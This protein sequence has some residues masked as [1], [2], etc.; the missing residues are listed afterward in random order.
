MTSDTIAQTAAGASSKMS[1]SQ[2]T[3]SASTLSKPSKAPSS[4]HSSL[5]RKDSIKPVQQQNGKVSSS[6]AKQSVQGARN[7][8]AA[9]NGKAAS[10]QS[11]HHAEKSHQK[12]NK[13]HPAPS[14][15]QKSRKHDVTSTGVRDKVTAAAAVDDRVIARQENQQTTKKQSLS[16]ETMS[17][18][19]MNRSLLL[20][21]I[22]KNV[23]GSLSVPLKQH[24][25]EKQML[26]GFFSVLD[27]MNGENSP[28]HKKNKQGNKKFR[29]KQI[30]DNFVQQL[31]KELLRAKTKLNL[32]KTSNGDDGGVASEG[33]T[34]AVRIDDQS[35]KK[36]SSAHKN[37]TSQSPHKNSSAAAHSTTTTTKD[38][39]SPPASSSAT[40][41][42][43]SHPSSSSPAS[44]NKSSKSSQKNKPSDSD[45]MD[46]KN[47]SHRNTT[48]RPQS[49]SAVKGHS[50]RGNMDGN[51][52]SIRKQFDSSNNN[53]NKHSP[54]SH[55]QN[56][57][58][59]HRQEG[60]PSEE[61][62]PFHGAHRREHRDYDSSS[63]T[64][65]HR[66]GNYPNSHRS[67]HNHG[68]SGPQYR[69]NSFHRHQRDESSGEAQQG[70]R[71]KRGST[72]AA[73]TEERRSCPQKSPRSRSD[74]T[75]DRPHRG[76]SERQLSHITTT[77]PHREVPSS[78]DDA[79]STSSPPPSQSLIPVETPEELHPSAVA[80]S[81]KENEETLSQQSAHSAPL[82]QNTQESAAT[83]THANYH[84]YPQPNSM[85]MGY[86]GYPQ[87][88]GYAM[89]GAQGYSYAA[90]Y[91]PQSAYAPSSAYTTPQNAY[92]ASVY[93]PSAHDQDVA[94]RSASGTTYYHQNATPSTP[95]TVYT[96][97]NDSIEKIATLEEKCKKMEER[98]KFLENKIE[99]MGSIL[100]GQIRQAHMEVSEVRKLLRI[101]K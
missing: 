23:E 49:A 40:E 86:G 75:H 69:R 93:P 99:S 30:S 57:R 9:E 43:T 29:E 24:L 82:S 17:L 22:S 90:Q 12:K 44:H 100:N 21:V 97:S 47:V 16:Q 55:H 36:S 56:G 37:M 95:T 39:R 67:S 25:R 5:T 27:H 87:H 19:T 1:S 11:S 35:H 50:S 32:K 71:W 65:N 66:N 3:A 54:P 10:G 2:K 45:T 101:Q 78:Q 92:T 34:G 48:R 73:S 96:T 6:G 8:T 46:N 4:T 83:P 28:H 13:Q 61:K 15:S 94:Y 18:I 41:Y 26:G 60:H 51:R 58:M 74:H 14:N 63:H 89:G 68:G 53:S 52:S 77:P 38:A 98:V 72:S 81:G 79:T 85:G 62:R 91:Y 64:S 33:T 42:Q 88:G 76:V 59:R 7:P 20:S 31:I 84:T 80:D 70:G